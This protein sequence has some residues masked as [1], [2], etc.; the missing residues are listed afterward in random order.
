VLAA[1]PSVLRAHLGAVCALL[2]DSG[3]VQAAARRHRLM[4]VKPVMLLLSAPDC[5]DVSGVA[6]LGLEA[7]ESKAPAQAIASALVTEL[8]LCTKEVNAKTRAQAYALL[9]DVAHALH[10]VH[11]PAVRMDTGAYLARRVLSQHVQR[12]LRFLS[13][14]FQA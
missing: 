12:F 6:V 14:W 8:V 3:A 10:D 11:P 9:V 4:C 1:R 13:T 2:A 5:P 7:G